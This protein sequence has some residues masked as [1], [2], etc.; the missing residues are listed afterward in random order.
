MQKVN[1]LN[2]LVTKEELN[3]LIQKLVQIPSTPDADGYETKVAEY[4]HQYFLDEE[5][6]QN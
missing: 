5:L 2:N 4:I 6:K 3:N 1:Q